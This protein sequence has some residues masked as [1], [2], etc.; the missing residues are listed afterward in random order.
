MQQ[1]ESTDSLAAVDA[2]VDSSSPRE[3]GVAVRVIMIVLL[4]MTLVG[5]TRWALNITNANARQISSNL[6]RIQG[7]YDTQAEV[8]KGRTDNASRSRPTPGPTIEPETK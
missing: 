6:T 7:H 3:N 1:T 2:F 4:S 5:A 8:Q